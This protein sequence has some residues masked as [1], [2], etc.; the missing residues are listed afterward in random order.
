M[1]KIV[2]TAAPLS[3]LRDPG[4]RS[5][6]G[7]SGTTA[8]GAAF[9]EWLRATGQGAWQ[10]L[11]L[12]ETH[13]E[14]GSSVK[15]V[16]S[17][18]KG[19]GI[20][21]SVRY[22]PPAF[23]HRE[24]TRRQLAD[25][26]RGNRSWLDD[27]S[28][29]AALTSHFGTDDWTRWEP[30]IRDRAPRALRSWREG[31]TA[32]CR[33]EAVTQWRLREAFVGLRSAAAAAGVEIIGD[34]PFYL[35]LQSPLVWAHREC[36]DLDDHGRPRSVSGVPDGPRA[37]FGRQVWG[38]PLY[39]WR[40]PER[41]LRLWRLRLDFCAG[42]YDLMRL[43][44]AKGFFNYGAMDPSDPS[45]DTVRSGPGASA[46]TA[47]VSHAR[48]RGLLLFAEDAGDRLEGLRRSLRRLKVP[49][50]RQLRFA[51]NEK[52]KRVEPAYADVAGYPENCLA[53]TSTH[54]TETLVGYLKLLK[55]AEL[56]LLSDHV[57]VQPAADPKIMARR[58][59]A[60][61]VASPAGRVIV[62]IQDWLGSTKRINV[63]GT[64]RP[65]ADPN[66]RYRL[67]MPIK[68]LPRLDWLGSPR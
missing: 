66:W 37:H 41:V 32:G 7:G 23:R 35:P 38:H 49:G 44:H 50:I 20:G 58:L 27:Y 9:I 51:Y 53:F 52:R 40:D 15:R 25:F 43:D 63:P 55:V 39:R 17:P 30:G 6:S 2:G 62:P 48:R 18:Y 54:D 56:R 10:L 36:F 28:F 61:T 24:P 46:L 31:L 47:V 22:L 12:S 8:A 33:R 60:A 42:F 59:I 5:R 13:L 4:A 34:L 16:P 19:Y 65:V 14:P 1:S 29:F 57:G 21:F 64:E 67:E 3:C 45:R 11:P 26:I 68:K